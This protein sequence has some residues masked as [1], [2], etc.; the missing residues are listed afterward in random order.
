MQI[1]AGADEWAADVSLAD[2][3]LL[4]LAA[5]RVGRRVDHVS[6]SA[7]CTRR[8]WQW[9]YGSC[10]GSGFTRLARRYAI[11]RGDVAE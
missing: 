6:R 3:F 11:G 1:G 4:Y 7:G 5:A 8:H 10:G 9:R 2:A